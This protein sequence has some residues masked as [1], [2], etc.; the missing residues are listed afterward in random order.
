MTEIDST[1]AKAEPSSSLNMTI[2]FFTL[3]DTTIHR[4]IEI[5]NSFTPG[6]FSQLSDTYPIFLSL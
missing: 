6:L 5:Y 2:T 4:V 3:Y 1:V